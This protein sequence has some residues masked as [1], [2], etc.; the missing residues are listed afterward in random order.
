MSPGSAFARYAVPLA[1][2]LL[3]LLL[4]VRSGQQAIFAGSL[5]LALATFFVWGTACAG[6]VLGVPQ[7]GTWTAIYL[8]QFT[9]LAVAA[10]VFAAQGLLGRITGASLPLVALVVPATLTLVVARRRALRLPE[11]IDPL[12]LLGLGMVA[13]VV[14]IYSRHLAALG[15]DTHEHLAWVRQILALGH[16]PLA[17]PGTEIVADYPRTFHV[18]T[19]LWSAAGLAPAAGP[20]VKAMPFLQ[21]ILPALALAEQLVDLQPAESRRRWQICLGIALYAYAF[22][23]LPLVYPAGDLSGT[24]RFSSGGLLL[25]PAVLVALGCARRAPRAIAAAIVVSPLL[26][27]WA[28]TWNPIVVVLLAAAGLPAAVALAVA[29][30]PPRP[31]RVP[32]APFAASSAAALLVLAQDP[33][34]VMS[35]AARAAPVRSAVHTAGLVTFDEAIALG[36]ATP[37]EKAVRESPAPSPAAGRGILA[38]AGSAAGG[39]IERPWSMLRAAF[40]DAGS[41]VRHP[42]LATLRPAFRDSLPVVPSLV[43]DWAGLPFLLVLLAAAGVITGRALRRTELGVA[44]RVLLS[45]WP[46]LLCTTVALDFAAGVARALDDGGH[47]SRIL[48]DYLAGAGFPVSLSFL[49]LPFAASALTIAEAVLPGRGPVPRRSR[50]LAAAGLAVLLAAPLAARLNLNK[51]IQHGGFWS[52]AHLR[53]L[54]ALRA[55]ERAI[56]PGDGVIVPAEHHTV[57]T[58]EHWVLPLGETASL[59]PYGDRRYLFDV[60]LGASYPLSW[61]DVEDGLCSTNREARAR[62]LERTGARWA[63]VRDSEAADDDEALHRPQM[64]A[65]RSTPLAALGARSPAVARSGDLFLFRLE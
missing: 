22:L 42:S 9:L 56:P 25:L 47:E 59:L 54:R 48:V 64:C 61:R 36:R 49:W 45:S 55:I 24:P 26:C 10:P 52:E 43:A 57:G 51:P 16:V 19:A 17:E 18:L 4:P 35:A 39:A 20:W 62:L 7:P 28:L 50:L 37:R 58:W 13:L 1:A 2:A 3:A 15:L 60:Y 32:L 14:A 27:A 41:V 38:V 34:V 44:G 12:A 11:S 29:L 6:K 30:R 31:L 23:L 8:G 53:D 33:W 5:A 40:R 63:L 21:S 46:G 65:G